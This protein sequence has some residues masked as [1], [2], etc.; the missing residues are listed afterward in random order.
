LRYGVRVSTQLF[1]SCS[2]GAN[3]CVATNFFKMSIVNNNVVLAYKKG[4][5]VDKNG[6]V[7]YKGCKLKIYLNKNYYMFCIKDANNKPRNIPVH[8]MQAY[9]KFGNKMFDKGIVVRHINGCSVYN[10]WDNIEIGTSSDNMLDI[11][12]EKRIEKAILASAYLKKYNNDDVREFYNKSKSYKKTKEM[13]GISSSGTLHYILN[14][15]KS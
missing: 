15:S 9:S 11:P 4:Y 1:G 14:K 3:P 7:Y 8:K 5:Y 10:S 2:Q 6:D 12:K 13:F